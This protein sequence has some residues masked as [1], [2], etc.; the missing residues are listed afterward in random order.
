MV[1]NEVEG[2]ARRNCSKEV[3]DQPATPDMMATPPRDPWCDQD[4]TLSMSDLH[5]RQDLS[6]SSSGPPHN[7]AQLPSAQSHPVQDKK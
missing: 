4:E 7:E 5:A 1:E 2:R 3:F 6:A